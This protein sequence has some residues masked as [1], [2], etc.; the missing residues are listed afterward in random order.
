MLEQNRQKYF[1]NTICIVSYVWRAQI[2]LGI[3][4]FSRRLTLIVYLYEH[5]LAHFNCVSL[6]II[7]NGTRVHIL[8]TSIIPF[9]LDAL[10]YIFN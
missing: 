7:V 1:S 10:R 4:L 8:Y 5:Q 2:H 3:K 9:F 6:I